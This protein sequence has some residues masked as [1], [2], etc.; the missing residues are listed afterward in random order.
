M[1]WEESTLDHII[2]THVVISP[3]LLIYE[4]HS[5]II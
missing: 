3:D 4:Y 5:H 1:Y 2:D